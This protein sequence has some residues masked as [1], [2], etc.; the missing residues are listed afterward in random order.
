MWCTIF[1]YSELN[2]HCTDRNNGGGHYNHSFFWKVMTS[3]SST[4]GPSAALKEAIDSSFG[5]LEEM[6][7]KFNAAAATRFGELAVN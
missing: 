5:S 7:N 3:P 4:N 1:H 2:L 6:K